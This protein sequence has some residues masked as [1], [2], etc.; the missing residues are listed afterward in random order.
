MPAEKF[1]IISSTKGMITFAGN[2]FIL[3]NLSDEL[4]ALA[5]MGR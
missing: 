4:F 5:W 3:T 2:S 1:E